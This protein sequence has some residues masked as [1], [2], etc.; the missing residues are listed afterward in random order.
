MISYHESLQKKNGHNSERGKKHRKREKRPSCE[1]ALRSM[2][3][4]FTSE[5]QKLDSISS[6]RNVKLLSF[7]DDDGIAEQAESFNF[8]KKG[9]VRPD[10]AYM[11]NSS[12]IC[13]GN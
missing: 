4:V 9:I 8:K 7:G 1:K 11:L 12:R 13:C 3:C 2:F 10:C 5:W 6:R